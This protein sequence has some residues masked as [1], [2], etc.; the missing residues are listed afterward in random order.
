MADESAQ[1]S[2]SE[3]EQAAY[4]RAAADV[5]QAVLRQLGAQPTRTAAVAFVAHLQAGVDQVMARAEKA[6]TGFACKAGCAHCCHVR[7]HALEPEV[8]RIVQSVKS[9]PDAMLAALTER[10]RLHARAAQGLTLQNHRLPCPFLEDNR[11]SIY[12]LRPAVC[13]KAHSLDVAKCATPGATIPQDLATLMKAEAMIQGTVE[14]YG[15]LALPVAGQEL[16]QAVL[17]A[18]L[19]PDIEVRWHAPQVDSTARANAAHGNEGAQ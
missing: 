16:G 12:A 15:A 14:A 18:L 6:G 8:F 11:C 2:L 9:L 13:R 17:A 19:D 10:L 3:A 5:R 4:L 7:V 1:A